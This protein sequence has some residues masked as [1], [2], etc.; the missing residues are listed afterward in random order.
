MAIHQAFVYELGLMTTV[1]HPNIIKLI[2]FVEDMETGAVQMILPWESNG[3][4]REFLQSGEWDVPERVSL[5]GDVPLL[6]DPELNGGKL[7]L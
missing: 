3:N 6:K 5:V 4:V 2:G 1:S 7:R